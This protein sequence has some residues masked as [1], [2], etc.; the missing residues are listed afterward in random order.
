MILSHKLEQTILL[1]ISHPGN[2]AHPLH[3]PVLELHYSAVAQISPKTLA[4]M[5]LLVMKH[6]LSAPSASSHLVCCSNLPPHLQE[7][8]RH[9]GS[10]PLRN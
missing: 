8:Y 6:L 10:L 5:H 3:P 9:Q 7:E 2:P 4:M 1:M